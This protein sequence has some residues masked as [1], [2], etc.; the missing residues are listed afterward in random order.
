MDK[1][2]NHQQV[3]EDLAKVNEYLAFE[4]EFIG[5]FT[6][7]I[8]IA[9]GVWEDSPRWVLGCHVLKPHLNYPERTEAE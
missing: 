3:F 8:E 4:W 6:K 5:F 9:E 1:K 2:I 7:K